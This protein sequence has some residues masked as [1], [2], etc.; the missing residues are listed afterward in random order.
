MKFGLFLW[1]TLY[2]VWRWVAADEWRWV[3]KAIV[4]YHVQYM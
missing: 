1:T 4:L 2:S 3:R